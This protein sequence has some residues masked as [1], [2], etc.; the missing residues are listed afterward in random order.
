MIFVGFFGLIGVLVIFYFYIILEFLK[1]MELSEEVEY[2]GY[3][4][5]V[6]VWF[7]VI[8]S[9]VSWNFCCYDKK[10]KGINMYGD[11]L[12]MV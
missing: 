8:C 9:I 2:L 12:C 5:K 11:R 4:V 7:L 1:M 6:V 10:I 3:V